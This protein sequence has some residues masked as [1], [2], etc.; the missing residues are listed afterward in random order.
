[1]KVFEILHA[2]LEGVSNIFVEVSDMDQ[3]IFRFEIILGIP[4]DN[5]VSIKEGRIV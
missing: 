4:S 5:I 3:A 2:T 1:M